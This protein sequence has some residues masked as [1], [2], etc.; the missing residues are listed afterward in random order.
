MSLISE[1]R[2]TEEAIKE[3]QERL[4]AMQ[5]DGKLQKEIEFEKNLR[6]LM[7]QYGKS[8][9][10]IIAILDP[11]SAS[12]TRAAAKA[13]PAA[14]RARKVKQYRNPHTNEVI[15]TKGGNHKI[16]KEWKA[17]WGSD[18]VEGWATLLG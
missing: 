3:L 14:K 17:K 2:A 5:Q 11:A 8:L 4:K 18:E 7:A 12:R 10:D 9:P 13:A 6:D 15:E 1:F 16:L